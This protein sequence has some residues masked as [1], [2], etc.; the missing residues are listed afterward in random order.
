M[1]HQVECISNILYHFSILC[2]AVNTFYPGDGNKTK[3][4]RPRLRTSLRPVLCIIMTP[5]QYYMH[6]LHSPNQFFQQF[7]YIG[8]ARNFNWVGSRLPSL[9]LHS[10]FVPPLLFLPLL[11][12]LFFCHPFSRFLLSLKDRTLKIHLRCLG[13][14]WAPPAGSRAEPQPKSNLMHFSFKRLDGNNFSQNKLTK[15]ANA[16]QFECMFM[17]YLKDWGLD[18]LPPLSKPLFS[19]RY[20]E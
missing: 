1:H 15:L 6:N 4:L 9:S 12:L 2:N 17:H 5:S 20:T 14:L 3:M 16:V 18:P 7:S 10:L 13:T 8:V 11:P 19:W